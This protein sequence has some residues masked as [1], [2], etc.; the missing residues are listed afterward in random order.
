[1]I[2]SRRA[3]RMERQHKRSG[4]M[5]GINLVSMMDIFTILVFFLLVNSAEVEVLP[6]AKAVRLPES[7][8]EQSPQKTIV[9]MIADKDILVQGRRIANIE[10]V[11]RAPEPVIAALKTELEYHAKRTTGLGQT[12]AAAGQITI[13]GDREIPYQLLKKVMLTCAQ[14]DYPNISLAVIH[15]APNGDRV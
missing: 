9:V 3:K 10:Q 6:N 11:L 2:M 14:A 15:K 8:A 13:M 5:A 4:R 1:M 12:S 7:T